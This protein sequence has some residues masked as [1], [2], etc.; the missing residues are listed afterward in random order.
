M[1]ATNNISF[2]HQGKQ[3]ILSPLTPQQVRED[4]IKMKEKEKE[5]ES[6]VETSTIVCRL[7]HFSLEE[8]NKLTLQNFQNRHFKKSYLT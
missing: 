2:T 4:E 8:G 6:R 3:I 7:F 5:K 1:M